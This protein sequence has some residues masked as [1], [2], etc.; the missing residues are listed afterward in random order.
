M[1]RA[2]YHSKPSISLHSALGHILHTD[3]CGP[4]RKFS[5]D[6]EHFMNIYEQYS[7]FH[8]LYLLESEDQAPDYIIDYLNWF[9]G[10]TNSTVKTLM[11]DGGREFSK[12]KRKENK[13]KECPKINRCSIIDKS[14]CKKKAAKGNR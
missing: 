2:S 8:K 10:Q 4:F 1:N 6:N 13:A 5:G 7:G 11:A 12:R 9:K 14:I 3:L